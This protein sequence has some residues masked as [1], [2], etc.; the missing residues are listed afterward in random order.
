MSLRSVDLLPTSWLAIC[1]VITTKFL[2]LT[3]S[4]K[5]T[6]NYYYY[7]IHTDT[8]LSFFPFK[9]NNNKTKNKS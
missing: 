8:H 9:P 4:P 2:Y 6:P 5:Y 1:L 7:I 3:L